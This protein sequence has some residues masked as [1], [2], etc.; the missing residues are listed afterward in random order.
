MS[1]DL[2]EAERRALVLPTDLW[3]PLALVQK[4]R[5]RAAN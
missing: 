2:Y 5:H 1:L 4:A 3:P